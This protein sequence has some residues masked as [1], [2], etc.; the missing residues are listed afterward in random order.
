VKTL[1]AKI[2]ELT[3]ENEFFSPV[4][5]ARRDCWAERNDRP[6]AQVVGRAVTRP[7]QIWEMDLTYIPHGFVYPALS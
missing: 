4:R 1:H 2:G 7:N 6:R 5:S 3:F